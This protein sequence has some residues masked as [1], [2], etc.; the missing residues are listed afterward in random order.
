MRVES[1]KE[2]MTQIIQAQPEDSSYEEI[3]K[4]LALALMIDRGVADARAG[5]TILHDEMKRRVASWQT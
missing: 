3:L 2:Q 4:E 1:V 5:R